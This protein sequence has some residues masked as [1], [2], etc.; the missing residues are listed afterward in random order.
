MS[1]EGAAAAIT[2]AKGRKSLFHFTR[3]GNLPSIVAMDA[4]L[5]SSQVRPQQAGQRRL[6]PVQ[7]MHGKQAIT[8]NAHLAIPEQMM[9]AAVTLEQFRAY[10]DQHVFFWPT[11]RDCQKMLATYSR[12][13]PESKFAVLEFDA[14]P[15]ITANYDAVKLTKYDSGSAPR[16]PN[17]CLYRKSM[18]MFLPLGMFRRTLNTVVPVQAS[19]IQEVLIEQR[20]DDL[21][22][23]LR[24]VYVDDHREVP[25]RWQKFVQPLMKLQ[26]QTH[27]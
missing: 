10:L 26:P 6:K 21:S 11:I 13:E 7:V 18:Q 16:Y 1:E 5:A 3:A 27:L 8:I 4:L 15:F 14:F 2:K 22:A 24:A 20:V 23:Y 19:E 25:E 9:D 17:R 12:R